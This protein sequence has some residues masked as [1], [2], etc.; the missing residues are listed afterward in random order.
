MQRAQTIVIGLAKEAFRNG[1][2]PKEHSDRRPMLVT[3]H[4]Q[5]LKSMSRVIEVVP[6]RPIVSSGPT[7]FRK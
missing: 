6:G 1:L 2:R 7:I 4:L 3:V 5:T